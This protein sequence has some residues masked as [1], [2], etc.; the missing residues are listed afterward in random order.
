MT[1]VPHVST[2]TTRMVEP[3]ERLLDTTEVPPCCKQGGGLG[4]ERGRE[5]GRRGGGRRREGREGDV[6][7]GGT[8]HPMEETNG[9]GSGGSCPDGEGVE[10]GV[11]AGG[12]HGFLCA[13]RCG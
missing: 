12:G 1:H 9:Q 10:D 3:R 4:W 6:D 5:G 11:G 8:L 7:E 2:M 13:G